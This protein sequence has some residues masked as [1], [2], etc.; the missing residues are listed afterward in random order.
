MVSCFCGNAILKEYLANCVNIIP[1][2][3][4]VLLCLEANDME[5]AKAIVP[6][7]KEWVRLALYQ[8]SDEML[9]LISPY[10]TKQSINNFRRY[11]WLDTFRTENWE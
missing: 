10:I 1:Y 7:K 5:T 3:S 9:E 11:R 8:T 4:I 6:L 2:K